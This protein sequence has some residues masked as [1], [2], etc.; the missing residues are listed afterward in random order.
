M[1]AS[2]HIEVDEETG[3]TMMTSSGDGYALELANE[4]I[5]LAMNGGI[6][7]FLGTEIETHTKQ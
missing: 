7:D 2:I 6:D 4:I 1:K 5:E 3:D